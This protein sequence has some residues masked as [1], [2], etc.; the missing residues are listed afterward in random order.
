MRIA[1]AGPRTWLLA[2]LAA[3]AS[4]IWLLALFGLGGSIHR[5]DPDDALLRPLPAA[6]TPV[7]DRLDALQQYA[8]SAN[9]PLFTDDRRPQPFVIDPNA[10]TG[11]GNDFDFVLTS[12]LRMPT[13]EMVIL[14]PSGGGRSLGVKVGE[15]PEGVA[16]WT[17]RSVES[18]AAVFDSPD[19]E[20]R[21]ELRQFDGVGG[22]SPTA[23]AVAPPQAPSPSQGMDHG[24]GA[25][26]TDADAPGGAPMQSTTSADGGGGLPT[27][28]ANGAMV[29]TAQSTQTSQEQVEAIRRRIEE[30]RARLR[31][32]AR[33]GQ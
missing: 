18:R 10:E 9:R 14:Q 33:Q 22:E 16:G 11:Q 13:L 1:D 27:M 26:I 20:V 30:R 24:P 23:M 29:E 32:Q 28:D 8:E 15:S 6:F 19:G 31:E 17:L 5:L 4:S 21:L 2:V 3:W 25:V 7:D 12:V